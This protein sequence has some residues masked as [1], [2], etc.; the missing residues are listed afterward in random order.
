MLDTRDSF[1]VVYDNC[2]WFVE[3][4]RW[5][6][7]V[8]SK[9]DYENQFWFSEKVE[10]IYYGSGFRSNKFLNADQAKEFAQQFAESKDGSC[11]LIDP[12][13][14]SIINLGRLP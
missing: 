3:R 12:S 5:W 9:I 6:W 8:W 13:K 14:R 10:L 1:R 11:W 7:P 2:C 4:K